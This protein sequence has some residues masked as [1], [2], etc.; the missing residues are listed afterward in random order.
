MADE[1]SVMEM[2]EL[3]LMEKEVNAKLSAIQPHLEQHRPRLAKAKAV[4]LKAKAKYDEIKSLLEPLESER[5]MLEGELAELEEKK[6]QCRFQS[7]VLE[8]GGI[9]PG[10]QAFVDQMNELAGD[11]EEARVAEAAQDLAI[12]SELE[13]L[14][15]RENG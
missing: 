4:I 11:P 8:G 13:A 12:E 3:L 10:T 6:R 5:I 15:A 7:R 9:R 2:A 14:K 1:G